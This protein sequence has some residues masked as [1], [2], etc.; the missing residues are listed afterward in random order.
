M[1]GPNLL[2]P[3]PPFRAAGPGYPEQHGQHG[4]TLTAQAQVP[5]AG[6]TGTPPGTADQT[7]PLLRQ[8]YPWGSRLRSGAAARR[9]RLLGRPAVVVGGV[10]GVRRFYDP[11]LRRRGAFP[12]PVKL[13]LFGAGALHGLD[14][15]PHHA[16]KAMLLGVL[17]AAAVDRLGQRAD[18]VWAQTLQRW[19]GRQQVVLF[20]EA[21]EVLAR[22]VLPWAGVELPDDE[23]AHRG[24]QLAVVV[25]GFATPGVPY[26]AA[27]LARVRLDRWARALVRETRAGTRTPPEGSALHQV[28]TWR[29]DAGRRLSDGVAA[30]E[31][32]NVVR[33]TVAV[34]WFVAFAGVALH[35]QPSWRQR[36][37]DGDGEALRAF[38]H[39]VRRCYPFVPV[40]AARA[41]HD[42][43]VLGQPVRRGQLVV[44]DVHGTTHD[45]SLWP[46][47]DTFRPE[48]F[49]GPVEEEALVPQGG[50]D[51]ATGHRCPGE[52]VTL[53]M[54]EVAVRRLAG[55]RWS[56]P[57]QDLGWSTTRMPTRPRSGVLLRPEPP[58]DRAGPRWAGPQGAGLSPPRPPPAAG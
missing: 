30:V 19:A 34:A 13:V 15:A 37:A 26:L 31:L 25:D 40:L 5:A 11:R 17:D 45:E 52:D 38:V 39:E 53:T 9:T 56:V 2:H 49:L 36:I 55:A 20:D 41:R 18:A 33:P 35:E 14:D 3:A 16:R 50:G 44:L 57:A 51:V 48:R 4:T 58:R 10:A 47:P 27:A 1:Y 22:A 32:L 43:D 12:P 7:L 21:V 42:Q 28:A 54:L 24:R 23:H 6:T 29:D 46:Q 8:G